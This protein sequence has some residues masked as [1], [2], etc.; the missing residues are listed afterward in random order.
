MSEH[1]LPHP[2]LCGIG[3][4]FLQPWDHL[5][6]MRKISELGLGNAVASIPVF[7]VGNSEED[8]R[9]GAR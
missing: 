4:E 6:G 5:P 2:I 1:Q 9:L 7:H 3:L 8:R